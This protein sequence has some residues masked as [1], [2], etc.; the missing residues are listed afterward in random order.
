MV[1]IIRA[2]YKSNKLGNAF[3]RRTSLKP[4]VFVFLPFLSFFFF[5]ENEEPCKLKLESAYKK[6]LKILCFDRCA[7]VKVRMT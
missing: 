1:L 4:D 2:I 5:H 7:F 3:V 6:K